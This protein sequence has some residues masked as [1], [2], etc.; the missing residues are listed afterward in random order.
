MPATRLRHMVTETDECQRWLDDAALVWPDL[1]DNRAALIRR[2]V[3]AGHS[4]I[5]DD[6]L[7]PLEARRTNRRRLSSP[8]TGDRGPS[9]QGIET[10]PPQPP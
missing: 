5:S 9:A 8:G 2:L 10:S 7:A 1:R 3:E 6:S 4:T